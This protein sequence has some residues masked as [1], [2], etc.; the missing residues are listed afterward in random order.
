[1]DRY[2]EGAS[3]NRARV[4]IFQSTLAVSDYH[5]KFRFMYISM[6]DS[7]INTFCLRIL[8]GIHFYNKVHFTIFPYITTSHITFLYLFSSNFSSLHV[9]LLCPGADW[10]IFYAISF[11]HLCL[12]SVTFS[13]YRIRLRK[14]TWKSPGRILKND[15]KF[16]DI[17]I[18]S[19]SAEI[20]LEE[21]Q[22]MF[23]CNKLSAFFCDMGTIAYYTFIAID[24]IT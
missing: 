9:T 3:S 1:M 18:C 11:I 21:L 14:K 23:Y 12:P 20:F 5:E 13:L 22:G 17:L 10:V 4:N 6:D 15:Q 8:L 24:Q 19:G 16:D 2:P 7:G